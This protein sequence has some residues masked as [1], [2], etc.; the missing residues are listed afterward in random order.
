MELRQIR[1]FTAVAREGTYAAAAAA[2]S[3][4][5]PA[6]WRQVRDL[7]RELGVKLFERAGRRVRL[8]I[9]GRSILDQAASAIATVDRLEATAADLRSSRAGVVAIAC[10][11][12]HLRQ[13]LAP[14]IGA[15]RRSHPGVAFEIREYGGGSTPG[16]GI[17]EDLLG[18]LVDLA[19]GVAPVDDPRFEGFPIYDVNLVVAV[20]D[21]HPW[22]DVTAVEVAQLRDCSLV[23]SQAGAY[24]R[25]AL[26]AACRRAGFEPL[27]AFDS[28][29]PVTVLALGAAGLG[30]AVTIDDAVAQP[31]GRP[32]PRLVEND[33]AVGD[34]VRL[35]WRA[36]AT[37]SPTVGAFVELARE[38]VDQRQLSTRT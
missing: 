31:S 30:L 7:E 12:P 5:Q 15:F 33:R 14:V 38:S 11:S 8:T 20:P 34:T 4:A 37:L 10:A 22:R 3:I 36:G 1:Y 26:E 29:S 23:C 21:D 25:G 27:V 19:T 2:L 28:A 24:S 6:L 13:F 16:R 32:W 9:D 18:G 17:P 35:G